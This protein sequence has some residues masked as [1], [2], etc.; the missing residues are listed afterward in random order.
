VTPSV[1]TILQTNFNLLGTNVPGGVTGSDGLVA[2]LAQAAVALGEANIP[3][4]IFWLDTFISTAVTEATMTH[5]SVNLSTLTTLLTGVGK[6]E[7]ALEFAP[8]VPPAVA[9][10]L[11]TNFTL[12]GTTVPGGLTGGDPLVAPLTQAGVDVAELNIPGAITELDTFISTA[13]NEAGSSV[14]SSTLITLVT[15]AVAIEDLFLTNSNTSI[16]APSITYG[17]SGSVTV[18]VSS[19]AGTP[20][21]NVSLSVDGGRPTLQPLSGG[22]SIF[23]LPGLNATTHSLIAI[24][25]PQ[26]NLAASIQ[27][28]SL[29]VNPAALSATGVNFSATAGAPFSG[30]VATFTNVSPNTA[31]YT[32]LINWGDGSPS[33]TV[34]VS[35]SGSS[36]PVTLTVTGS[37]TYADAK[38]YNVSVQISNPNVITK[39][40][41]DTATV[42][43]LGQGVVNGLTGT[44]GFWHNNNGQAL[45]SSF[46]GGPTSTA[47]SAWLATTFS[48]LYGVSAGANSLSGKTNAQVAAYYQM[49]F[50][51]PSSGQAQVLAT[52]LNVY[53][54]TL[55]LGGTTAQAY[56]FSVSAVGLGARSYNV[57]KD[58]AAFGVANNTTLNVY[59]LLLA[60]N[61]KAVKGVLYGGDATLQQEAADLLGALNQAG[62]IG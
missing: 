27:T 12:L 54:T 4:A 39:T 31:S 6:L 25:L 46:N 26:G 42:T 19:S 33:T 35:T 37:H 44:I 28:G 1:V 21:G 24:Y 50:A 62:S 3:V 16:S 22:S 30:T 41:N 36:L 57:G 7:I 9:Q 18:T 15:G 61:M 20:T 51:M 52:A 14:N 56:G 8:P 5:P 45:I 43:N 49:L 59:E 47:L 58:G 40:V 32:A 48:N 55:S 2:P 11:T 17:S 38:V 10:A 29:I 34:I 60:V 23:T 53:A 13:V